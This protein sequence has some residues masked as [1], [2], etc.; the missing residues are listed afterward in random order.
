MRTLALEKLL[1]P[2][3]VN[4]LPVFYAV[5]MSITMYTKARHLSAPRTS[6]IQSQSHH[7]NSR[8]IF[9]LPYLRLT[10]QVVLYLLDSPSKPTRVTWPTRLIL[11]DL[12]APAVFGKE[13]TPWSS[14]LCSFFQF[15]V[16]SSI[17]PSSIYPSTLPSN[18]TAYVSPLVW[19]TKFHTHTK[20]TKLQFFRT[21]RLYC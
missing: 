4:K 14:S 13:C 21:W 17:L 10:F 2:Q 16:T 20:Q 9:I 12:I 7:I 3:L 19:Q 1:V 11:L 15:A 6:W 18:T 5:R 8:S